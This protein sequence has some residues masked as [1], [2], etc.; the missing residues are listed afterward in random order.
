MLDMIRSLYAHQAWADASILAAVA[1]HEGAAQ[2]ET[3]RKA[4]HHIAVVQRAF[5][6]LFLGRP[7]DFASEMR[8]PESLEEVQKLFRGIHAEAIAFAGH[9]QEAQLSEPFEM[10]YL[11]GTRLTHGEAHI[12]V[13]MHSQ[14]H[15]GQCA[16][17]LRALGGDP[18][19]VDFI[20]WLK[21]RP[22]VCA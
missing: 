3:L 16:S 1:K 21:D 13:V 14:H 4:L 18:P 5:L 10:P 22:V 20:I 7:F 9:L 17:R 19:T 2:D 11:P 6:A 8:T 15:R 12:Q